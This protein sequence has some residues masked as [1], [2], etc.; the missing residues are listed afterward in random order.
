MSGLTDTTI[1]KLSSYNVIF[2]PA[3][4]LHRT[5]NLLVCYAN[6]FTS[7]FDIE[8]VINFP[9]SSVVRLHDQ[10]TFQLQNVR[11]S[12]IAQQLSTTDRKAYSKKTA[13]NRCLHC[14]PFSNCFSQLLG[15]NTQRG[16]WTSCCSVPAIQRLYTSWFVQKVFL[17]IFNIY[18]TIKFII[19]LAIKR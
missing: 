2:Y 4:F 13:V 10:N 19:F 14:L 17:I 3:P 1:S 5:I 11:T 9:N 6:N 16:L 12:N 7:W 18:F 15:R 8:S